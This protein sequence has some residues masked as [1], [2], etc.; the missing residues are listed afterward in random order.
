MTPFASRPIIVCE[1]VPTLPPAPQFSVIHLAFETPS[2][3]YSCIMLQVEPKAQLLLEGHLGGLDEEQVAF[4]QVAKDLPQ[5]PGV[6]QGLN[7]IM[8][9]HYV[10]AHAKATKVLCMSV[11]HLSH[12]KNPATGG[13]SL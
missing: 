8:K 6:L 13:R 2:Q 4:F 10:P 11:W 12:C 7:H 3:W 1:P 9:P 5:L